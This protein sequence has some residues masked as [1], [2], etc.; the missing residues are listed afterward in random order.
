MYPTCTDPLESCIQA[1]TRYEAAGFKRWQLR[2]MDK[3]LYDAIWVHIVEEDLA[4]AY[5]VRKRLFLDAAEVLE[6]NAPDL[7]D[8]LT[9][10]ELKS[11]INA[12]RRFLHSKQ[13]AMQ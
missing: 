12:V 11:A 7:A 5:P 6:Q 9:T 10:G 2:S 1:E 3:R 4:W 13:W 8:K